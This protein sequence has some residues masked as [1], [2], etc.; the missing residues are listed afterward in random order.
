M[1]HI[2]GHGVVAV[3]E[4]PCGEIESGVA[5]KATSGKTRTLK[6]TYGTPAQ[7]ATYQTTLVVDD[8]PTELIKAKTGKEFTSAKSFSARGL[9]ELK[10]FRLCVNTQKQGYWMHGQ[11]QAEN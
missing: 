6:R 8:R 11:E 7:L 4:L 5:T 2:P 1:A 9:P 10:G 3:D